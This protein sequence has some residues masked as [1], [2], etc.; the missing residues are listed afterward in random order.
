MTNQKMKMEKE[1]FLELMKQAY[2]VLPEI[3]GELDLLRLADDQGYNCTRPIPKM[4]ILNIYSVRAELAGKGVTNANIFGYSHLIDSIK[5][6]KFSKIR[7]ATA[8]LDDKE[9]L[10]FADSDL[11][12][13]VGCLLII[14][15]V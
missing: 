9:I 15:E 7:I 12:D 6:S 1:A 14:R 5:K 11:R 3:S 13:L 10:L 2:K 8:R 4:E